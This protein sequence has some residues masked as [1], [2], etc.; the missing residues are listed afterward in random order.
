M[1]ATSDVINLRSAQEFQPTLE[2][3]EG[4]AKRL[5]SMMEEKQLT[6]Y[7]L[8]VFV[9][10]GGCSGLQYGMTFDNEQRE[11]DTVWYAHGLQVMVDPISA[12]YLAGATISYQ[13]DNMLA[14]AF[15]IDNPNAIASC[16]CGHSFRTR[17][18]AAGDDYEDGYASG[19]CSCGG[20]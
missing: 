15:K 18:Q 13:Q 11:G 4:A 19:G 8:R 14:G 3:T 16:G 1:T 20:Y 2:I 5:Q 17:D 6:G 10:G 9:S 7:G 12:R